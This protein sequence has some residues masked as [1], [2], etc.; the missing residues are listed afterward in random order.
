MV[1]FGRIYLGVHS[2]DQ[3]LFGG[4]LGATYFFYFL[5]VL[6][7]PLLHYL[8]HFTQRKCTQ[9]EFW[10]NVI[11]VL[12]IM[13]VILPIIAALAYVINTSTFDDP[14]EWK[15]E[16]MQKWNKTEDDLPDNTL[17]K[18][19]ALRNMITPI[20]IMGALIGIMV[21]SYYFSTPIDVFRNRPIWKT[22]ARLVLNIILVIP[23][24]LM[25]LIPKD[26]PLFVVIIFSDFL[27]AFLLSLMVPTVNKYILIKLKLMV[28]F[29]PDEFSSRKKSNSDGSGDSENEKYRERNRLERS[30]SPNRNIHNE[31]EID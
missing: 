2:I 13:F 10:I 9:R 24:L 23:I 16:V 17:F 4:L 15:D 30:R 18:R 29:V 31:E 21:Y 1:L 12:V 14:K 5:L 22:L 8:R 28:P 11:I 20:G 26:S 25:M 7:D 3:V 19:K 6:K 27:V